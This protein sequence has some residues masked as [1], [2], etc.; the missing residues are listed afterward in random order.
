MPQPNTVPIVMATI[1]HVT[2][3]AIE[4]SKRTSESMPNTSRAQANIADMNP[5]QKA[6]DMNGR[7]MNDGFAPTS[8]MVR[9]EKRRA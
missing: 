1:S 3:F 6:F 2:T 7:R 9:I 4:G 5:T 8:C